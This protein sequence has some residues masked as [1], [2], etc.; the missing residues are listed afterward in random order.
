MEAIDQLASRSLVVGLFAFQRQRIGQG[1]VL[2]FS[3]SCEFPDRELGLVRIS[4]Q[5]VLGVAHDENDG[6]V[7]G[8][9]LLC[10]LQDFLCCHAPD[11]FP[12]A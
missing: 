11:I 3:L 5:D 2:N 4:C 10:D 8:E 1:D 6:F 9:V 12:V 7:R